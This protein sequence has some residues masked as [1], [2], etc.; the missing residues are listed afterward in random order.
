MSDLKTIFGENA[1]NIKQG[2]T[3]MDDKKMFSKMFNNQ[4]QNITT[5]HH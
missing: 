2:A 1:A 4:S 3:T 5:T